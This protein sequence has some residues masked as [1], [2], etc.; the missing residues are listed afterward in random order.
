MNTDFG[1]F[2]LICIII[3]A[4][5]AFFCLVRAI[6]GPKI[7]DRIMAANMIGTLTMAIILL[8]SVLLGESYIIDVALVYA[9]ISFLGVIV[10]TKIYMG[11]YFQYKDKDR[12]KKARKAE[13]EGKQ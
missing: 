10:I 3:L 6:R 2:F 9:V 4:V 1:I 5:A 13:T 11:R 12:R 8:M 7:A